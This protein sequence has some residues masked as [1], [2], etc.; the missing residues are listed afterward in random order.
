LLDLNRFP[1]KKGLFKGKFVSFKKGKND[2]QVVILEAL[3]PV[4][5]PP[6]P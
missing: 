4:L 6:E 1:L 5:T 3:L 2:S